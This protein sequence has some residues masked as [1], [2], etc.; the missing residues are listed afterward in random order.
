MKDAAVRG[1]RLRRTGLL[2]A[3]DG[4]PVDV[5]RHHLALQAQDFGPAKWSIAQRLAGATDEAVEREVS[6]GR[7]LRTHVLR[8]TWH[9]VARDDLRWLMALSGPRVQKG[10]V[11]RYVQ[12]GL[13]AKTRARAERVIS[14]ELAGGNHLTRAQLGEI[15]VKARVNV[16]G[17]RLPHL[18]SHCELEGMVCSGRVDGK[19]Q[20]YAL[21]DERVPK[22]RP[23]TR[24]RAVEELVRRYLQSHGPATLR[25]LG[26]W[27]GLTAGDLRPGLEAAGAQSEDVAGM[28]L[29]HLDPSPRGGPRRPRVLLLQAY[30]EYVVGYT[31]TRYLGDPRAE[32][33]RAAFSDRSLPPSTLMLGTNVAGHWRRS[34]KQ[35]VVDV[36][37]VLYEALRGAD[38]DALDVAVDELG[39]YLGKTPKLL[40]SAI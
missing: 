32:Q 18:L 7:I 20:T 33:A 15:L 14:K 3:L 27:S 8:P 29:W 4:G 9:F 37:V 10:L 38:A 34:V 40:T 19:R 30:D 1:A 21:F 31:Q 11:S 36:E 22:G 28:T 39:R 23:V 12:L 26:W 25:D 24:P 6:D 5:V 2:R 13:D 17:Q 35:N 16:E